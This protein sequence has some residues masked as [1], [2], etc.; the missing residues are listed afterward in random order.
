MTDA[1]QQQ[2]P[3]AAM[4]SRPEVPPGILAG[5]IAPTILRLAVPT[6]IVLVVQVLVGVAE[7][8]FLGRLGTSALAGVVMVFPVLMLMQMMSNGG[9]GGGVASAISRALGAR[10][11]AD[12][13][14]L[15]WHAF[16]LA[17]VFG[18]L[19][20]V[21]AVAGGTAL[22]R[23]MGGQGE[24][25]AAAVTYS[26]VVF[27]G[28][29]PIWIVALLSA[30]LRGAGDFKVPAWVTLASAAFLI[31]LS[32][33]FIFG[34]GPIPRLEILGGGL[35]FVIYY[36]CAGLALVMY[37]R[38]SRSPL[39]LTPSRLEF[40]WIKDILGVGLL[41]AA[42]TVQINLTVVCVTALVG[43]FGAEAIAGY[44]I[45][46]RIEYVLVPLLFGLGSAVLTMV[47]VN[48]GAGQMA[49]AR[50][51]AWIGAGMGFVATELIG[52]A[53]ALNPQAWLGLFSSEPIV[54]ALGTRY[55]QTVAPFYGAIG[56][57]MTLYFAGQGARWVLWPIL[58]GTLRMVIVILAGGL[59][60]TRFGADL[61]TLFSIVAAG[62]VCLGAVTASMAVI[63]A[64]W[65]RP[66]PR[67]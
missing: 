38:S 22:Y 19:F 48:V 30:A 47:G 41:S 18:L 53:V 57:G 64:P 36:V 63:K 50:Q 59:A 61:P 1:L 44:G 25:L 27:A 13:E 26:N 34:W 35:A 8:Y 45:G 3:P 4:P 11:R 62:I 7:T 14:A 37:L 21:A 55:L 31:P 15:L 16:V 40:R 17:L 24:G 52:L 10:R 2:L 33:A 42:G 60:V 51:I 65:G 28:A 6:L 49:R 32:P 5:P 66:L 58:A 12:A 23:A 46:S 67:A 43:G 29:V 56:L 54:L 20:T 39:K 9:I